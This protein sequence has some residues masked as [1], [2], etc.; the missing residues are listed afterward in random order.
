RF[1]RLVD[2]LI[3]AEVSADDPV[4]GIAELILRA[5]DLGR[6][7]R[8][9]ERGIETARRRVGQHTQQQVERRG[10]DVRAGRDV[11]AGENL[12]GVARAPQGPAAPAILRRFLRVDVL[13]RA[14]GLRYRAEKRLNQR[15][16]LR[17][18]ELAGHE[19][20]RVV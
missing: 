2:R 13:Q 3:L 11:I 12:R 10:V 4:A 5:A 1:L 9:D 16:R 8:L 19:Q 17:L 14:F 6:F 18:V 20:D 7:L 15:E